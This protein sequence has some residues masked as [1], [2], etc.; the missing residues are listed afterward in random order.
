M[1]T[2]MI[3]D[4]AA[5]LVPGGRLY[6]VGLTGMRRFVQRVMQEHFGNYDKLKQ[7]PDYTVAV[8]VR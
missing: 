4:A 2:I 5:H 1:L 8:S 3:A 7:G 6:I